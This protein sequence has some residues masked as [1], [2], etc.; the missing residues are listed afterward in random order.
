MGRQTAYL[1]LFEGR[2]GYPG[3]DRLVP[4]NRAERVQNRARSRNIELEKWP[5]NGYN[6]KQYG[7]NFD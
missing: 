5:Q 3:V 7:G 6:E 1:A 2:S 4:K